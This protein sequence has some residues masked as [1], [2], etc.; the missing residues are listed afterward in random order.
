V[1]PDKAKEV[2]RLRNLRNRKLQHIQFQEDR[3]I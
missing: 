3:E 2:G 1:N